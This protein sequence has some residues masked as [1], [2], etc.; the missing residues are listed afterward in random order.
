MAVVEA[1]VYQIL[2]IV[3]GGCYVGSS[4][5]LWRRLRHHETSLKHGR[6]RNAKLQGA[7]NKYGPERFDFQI[8]LFC[9]K[10]D[11]EMYEQLAIDGF[12][13]YYDKGGYNLRPK[14]FV[15]EGRVGSERQKEATRA[16]LSGQKNS[17]LTA[18]LQTPDRQEASRKKLNSFR[19]NPIV[20]A[21]RVAAIKAAYTPEKRASQAAAMLGRKRSQE[22]IEKNRQVSLRASAARK[23]KG[24]FRPVGPDGRFISAPYRML[25]DTPLGGG[26]ALNAMLGGGQPG[27]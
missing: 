21:K 9:A 17:I 6:H 22:T 1:G 16:R 24:L 13:A 11:L 10:S 23:A 5:D 25:A 7:W 8:V 3:K 27:Q 15:N 19:R 2:D 12:D 18:L 4:G 20:E 26:T 14:A